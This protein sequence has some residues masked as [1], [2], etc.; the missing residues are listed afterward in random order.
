MTD[1]D[2]PAPEAFPETATGNDDAAVT[3]SAP[4]FRFNPTDEELISN[5]LKRKV[6]RKSMRFYEIGEVDVYK[7]KPSDLPG[8]FLFSLI[9]ESSAVS[10][11][12]NF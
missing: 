2:L 8:S 5:Y 6:Q 11:L 9:V 1:R 10:W 3:S 12:F 7:I 4:S